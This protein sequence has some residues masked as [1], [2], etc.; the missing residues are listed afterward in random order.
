MKS[1][2]LF[3]LL[4]ISLFVASQNLVPGGTIVSFNL[5][6]DVFAPDVKIGQSADFSV[7]QD[8]MI[9]GKVVIPANAKVRAAIVDVEKGGPHHPESRV[10]VQIYEVTASDGSIVELEDC[11]LFT[12]GD[13]G[14]KQRGALLLKGSGKNCVSKKTTSTGTQ[15]F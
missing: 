5:N 9:K 6:K 1:L 4:A 11:F 15:K 7:T 3:P 12:M 10:K 14:H 2:L 8:V 13:G